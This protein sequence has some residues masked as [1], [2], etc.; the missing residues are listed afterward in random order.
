MVSLNTRVARRCA[1]YPRPI[2]AM[3]DILMIDLPPELREPSLPLGRYRP[4]F[5]ETATEQRELEAWF[6]NGGEQ[7]HLL[8]S[9]ASR[10]SML[11]SDHITVAHY[12]RPVEGW[13][14]A[15]LC[16]WPPNLTTALEELQMF[17]RQAY[18]VELFADREQL[19]QASD[20]LLAVLKRRGTARIEIV[21]PDWSPPPG[22]PLS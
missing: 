17:A 5:V 6:E 12:G 2:L 11:S 4:I 15:L 19:E 20:R 18:T 21:M 3:P 13:P 16:R 1:F 10:S 22:T 8:D 9:L 14:Y 7:P